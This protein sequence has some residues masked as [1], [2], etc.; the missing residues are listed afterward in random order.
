M[1]DNIY[2]QSM[3]P[4]SESECS[5][6]NRRGHTEPLRVGPPSPTPSERWLKNRLQF[7]WNEKPSVNRLEA[8]GK[9]SHNK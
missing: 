5:Y 8:Q 9:H 3:I 4:L 1:E 7:N 6:E 2:S